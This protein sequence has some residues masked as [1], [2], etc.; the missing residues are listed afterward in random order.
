VH[1]FAAAFARLAM[2]LWAGAVSAVAFAVAPRVFSFFGEDK[3]RAGELMAPIFRKVDFF[4][5]GVALFFALVARKSRWRL[6]IALLLAAAAAANAFILGPRI[7]GGG[8]TLHHV[9]EA[10]WGLIL[11][12]SAVLAIFGQGAP[13]Q[14]QP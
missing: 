9:A 8:K 11:F 13:T 4:G 6:A 12:W 7:P 10:L 5:L 3:A 2:G 14:S 1:R